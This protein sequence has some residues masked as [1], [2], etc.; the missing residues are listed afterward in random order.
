MGFKRF[1]NAVEYVVLGL[2]VLT[3]AMLF[4]NDQAPLPAP[5]S[6]PTTSLD[7]ALVAEGEVVFD[8]NC[9]S[10]HGSTGGGGVGPA[11]AGEVVSAFPDPADEEAVVAAGRGGM[12]SFASKLTEEEI[13]AVVAYTRSL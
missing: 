11:L 13:A 6:G 9:S 4:L 12:P 2:V 8:E 7:P 10:C 1:V 3:V 5:T